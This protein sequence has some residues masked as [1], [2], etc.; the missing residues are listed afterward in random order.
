MTIE[1]SG[2]NFEQLKEKLREIQNLGLLQD[3][4]KAPPPK[5]QGVESTEKPVKKAKKIEFEEKQATPPNQRAA[6]N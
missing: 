4:K 6:M 2:M 1:T 5:P 3:K